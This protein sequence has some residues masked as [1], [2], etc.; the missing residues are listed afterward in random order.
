MIYS[1]INIALAANA[2]FGLHL[3]TFLSRVHRMFLYNLFLFLVTFL[4]GSLPLWFR[5]MDERR[6][7]NLLAFSGSFLLSI[8]LLH[9]LPE[10][11]EEIGHEAGIFLLAG[12]FFQLLIQ[13]F[14]HGVEHGHTHVHIE[15]HQSHHHHD[16]EHH[17]HRIPLYSIVLG[18]SLHAFMEGIPLGFNFRLEGTQTSLY[19][20]VAAHKLPESMLLT[21]LM[22]SFRGKKQAFIVLLLFSL[23]TPLASGMAD[24]LGK[25]YFL[26]SRIITWIVPLVAGAFI[27]IATTIFFESGTRQHL[28]TRNKILAIL[29]GVG[30]GLTTLFLE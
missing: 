5:S 18:L 30:I 2:N 22:L 28:L 11:F 16:H 25:K 12:F 26:M 10:T 19:L 27:H 23:I 6:T 17:I 14:T 1:R 20:A 29:L 24:I 15:E 21:S 9:L 7:N 4:G 13:R 8:T 3:P